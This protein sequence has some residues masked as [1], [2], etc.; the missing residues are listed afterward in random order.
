MDFD[1]GLIIL[2]IIVIA[3]IAYMFMGKSDTDDK[4]K[5]TSSTIA[6]VGPGETN[7]EEMVGLEDGI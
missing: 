1:P 2:I 5:E 3:V 4:K 7:D 6:P